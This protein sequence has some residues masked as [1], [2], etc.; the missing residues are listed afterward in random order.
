VI[1][2][3]DAGEAIISADGT[4]RH[5]AAHFVFPQQIGDMPLRKVVIYG[6]ADLSV[7]Y[8]LRGG[9]NGDAWITF[10]VY[11][12]GHPSSIEAPAPPP[13][14]A[15]DGHS[16]WFEGQLNG[17]AIKTGYMLVQRGGWYLESR[18]TIPDTAGQIGVDR[19]VRALADVPWTWNSSPAKRAEPLPPNG[20]RP[21]VPERLP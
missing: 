19:T 10:F 13:A 17:M 9:G 8:S 4:V 12:V 21:K 16:R 18:Y 14:T 3:G 11:P 5:R 1:Q 6:P 15:A 20:F 2:G 7:D